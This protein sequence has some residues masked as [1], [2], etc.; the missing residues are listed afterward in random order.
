MSSLKV[1]FAGDDNVA[2]RVAALV[3]AGVRYRLFT[4][5]P[6][7]KRERESYL[8]DGGL[9]E[10]RRG[11]W[12]HTIVDSGVFSLMFG[13]A[14]GEGR[15]SEEFMRGWMHRLVSFV[16]ENGLARADVAVVE[17]DCQKIA[18][19]DVAWKLRREMREL[20]PPEV[21]IINVYHVEDGR[22]G[23]ERLVEFADYI[24]VGFPELRKCY[25]NSYSRV[26]SDLIRYAKRMKPGI[27]VHMLG[28]TEMSVITKHKDCTTCDSTS[29]QH[30]LRFGNVRV[31]G[32]SGGRHVSE[33]S[34]DIVSNRA[35]KLLDV[36]KGLDVKFRSEKNL[37]DSA[38]ASIL[39]ELELSRY[40]CSI[41]T[42]E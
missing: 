21:E 28:C 12:R 40:K 36:A 26:G 22:E 39:A 19:A 41:G 20:L 11:L 17:V 16:R 6:F 4:S 30:G 3:A 25:P 13:A 38:R 33:L 32:A 8:V 35:T 5:Y 18:G 34:D 9:L 1:H 14:S 31:P 29:W 27:K 24:A 23:F 10:A 15:R 2:G 42:Q 7:I 37:M